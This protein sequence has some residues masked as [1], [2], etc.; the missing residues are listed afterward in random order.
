[1]TL[2]EVIELL[3]E[4]YER[5]KGKEYVKDPL[6]FA[7]YSVWKKVDSMKGKRK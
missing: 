3:K 7:L 6:A 2:D 4:E 1:V 5:A